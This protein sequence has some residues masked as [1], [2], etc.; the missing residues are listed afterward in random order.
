MKKIIAPVK[1]GMFLL[2]L[3]RLSAYCHPV[4]N[5]LK[6]FSTN[7]IAEKASL[8]FEK[9]HYAAGD[10]M[11]FKPDQ[12]ATSEDLEKAG[13]VSLKEMVLQKFYGRGR[14]AGL[15]VVDGMQ[16]PP[17]FDIDDLDADDIETVGTVYGANA[18]MYGMRAGNGVWVIT[19]KQEE[20]I[21]P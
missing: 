5:K 2:C 4:N 10:T 14:T 6:T 13:G 19:T 9:P 11:Y 3:F 7:H 16:M 21:D 17:G 15:I 20:D 12:I 8:Y 1:A 18:A